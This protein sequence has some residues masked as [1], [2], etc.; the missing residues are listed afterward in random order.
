MTSTF[1][2]ILKVEVLLSMAKVKRL[3]NTIYPY[4]KI[5]KL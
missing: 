1:V 5:N 4:N 2:R 3:D